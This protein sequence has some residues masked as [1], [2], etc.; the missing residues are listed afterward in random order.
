MRTSYVYASSACLSKCG[1]VRIADG[2]KSIW[3]PGS[4]VAAARASGLGTRKARI[5][6]SRMHWRR[7]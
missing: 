3:T 2:C 5:T 4:F 6:L 1:T 7:R